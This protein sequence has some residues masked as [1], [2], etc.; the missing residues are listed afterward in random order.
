V[1]PGVP[2]MLLLVA[3]RELALGFRAA[4]SIPKLSLLFIANSAGYFLGSIANE[5]VGGRGG[6]LLWGLLYGLFLGS[7]IAALLSLLQNEQ[8]KLSTL[9]VRFVPFCG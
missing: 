7:G 2:L 8:P 3:V 1:V 4:R 5:C 6:M 9:Y